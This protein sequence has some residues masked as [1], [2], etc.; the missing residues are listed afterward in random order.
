[1]ATY[2]RG[3]MLGAGVDPRM[4][5]Q[6]FSGFAN[7]GMIQGQA[8]AGI[9]DSIKSAME[10]YRAAKKEKAADDRMIANALSFGEAAI[11][12]DPSIAEVVGGPMSIMAD[13]NATRNDRMAAA[14]SIRELS[15]MATEANRHRE[16]MALKRASMAGRG[17]GGAA[18]E[19]MG[20]ILTPE[21]FNALPPDIQATAKVMPD[22]NYLL[23]SVRRSAASGGTLSG[24][25]QTLVF[26]QDEIDSGRELGDSIN[27]MSQNPDGTFNVRVRTATGIDPMQRRS[28]AAELMRSLYENGDMQ[29]AVRMANVI[30]L[31]NFLGQPAGLPEVEQFL[32]IGLPSGTPAQPSGDTR[33]TLNSIF[34]N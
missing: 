17:S 13:P 1:M 32:G 30:G 11:K 2:G 19:P 5:T 25:G 29:G 7:A 28:K 21:E 27:I 33:P 12:V 8:M 26:T 4:F 24:E 20:Q 9:G 6:D 18:A 16:M 14:E 31:K 22:G 34:G 23:E 10:G 15:Q 3:Q